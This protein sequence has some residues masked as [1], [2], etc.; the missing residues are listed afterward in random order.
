MLIN[1]SFPVLEEEDI[2]ELKQDC[3]EEE[4]LRA[5]RSIG[6]HKAPGP[7]GYQAV[8]F[9]R[10]WNVTGGCSVGVC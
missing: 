1:G 3:T 9:K 5:L 10:F 8:F 2:G 6:S 7:D 4:M